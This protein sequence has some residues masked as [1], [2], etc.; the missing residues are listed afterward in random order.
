MECRRLIKFGRSSFVVSLPRNWVMDHKLKKGDLI[1][2]E[3]TKEHI[4]LTPNI[5]KKKESRQISLSADAKSTSQ[6]KSELT[7]AYLNNYDRIKIIGPTEEVKDMISSFPGLEVIQST[8]EGI[9]LQDLYDQ[10]EVALGPLFRRLDMIVRAMFKSE[11]DQLAQWHQEVTR[12]SLLVKRV[13]RAALD[14]FGTAQALKLDQLGIMRN[15]VMAS[16]LFRL[17][18][19]IVKDNPK[20]KEEVSEVFQNIMNGFHTS[21]PKQSIRL[22]DDSRLTEILYDLARVPLD[23]HSPV[24]NP[25]SLMENLDKET[26]FLNE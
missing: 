26:G 15:W 13:L 20:N 17:S 10:R 4:L 21:T 24:V 6:I 8:N 19:E 23:F 3:P 9:I 5:S 14:D 25:K 11:K 7:A 1:F 12:L 22:E 18:A 2:M 16:R